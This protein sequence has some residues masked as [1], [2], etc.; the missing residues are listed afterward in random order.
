MGILGISKT[1]IINNVETCTGA[2]SVEVASYSN[3][4]A[5]SFFEAIPY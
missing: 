4:S 5:V 1:D 3:I 2:V